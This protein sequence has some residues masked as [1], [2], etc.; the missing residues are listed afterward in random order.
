MTSDALT[1]G[2]LDS[3]QPRFPV[4]LL[5]S[6][7]TVGGAQRTTLALATWL[8]QQGYPVTVA[9]LYDKDNLHA[10]WQADAV[11][12]IINLDSWG[13]KH[14]PLVKSL[15]FVRGISR[16][17]TLLLKQHF[18][19]VLTF[20]HHSDLIGIPLAW[21]AR[22]PVRVANHRG[23]I[24]GFPT[25]LEKVHSRMVNSG[26]ASILVTVTEQAYAQA[27][28]AGVKREHLLVIPNGV[29][30]EL[31][32]QLEA[33]RTQTRSA[34]GIA[35]DETLVL[36]VGRLAPEKGQRYLVEAIPEV[37]K[38]AP[39]TLFAFAGDG[40]QHSALLRAAAETGVDGSI[41]FLGVRSDI[42]DLL[43][44]CDLFVLPSLT[45]GMPNA[46][47]EA[48]AAGLPVVA[49]RAG[50]VETLIHQGETGLL[51][52]TA[53]SHALAEAI[54]TLLN[55]QALRLHVRTAA[56]ALMETSY[57]RSLMCQRFESM[58]QRLYARK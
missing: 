22:V 43:T 14:N 11:F 30:I 53:D 42:P 12:P 39:R 18:G 34:L 15:R 45:E 3:T 46:L 2:V 36:S 9:F 25:W 52:P 10:Q 8:Q 47:M 32:K 56:R 33:K 20:T 24:F 35:S 1:P 4:L 17:L 37:L 29:D 6:Q 58:L 31:F 5:G 26:M 57:S 7:M 16:L 41:R 13:G 38:Q 55:D 19:A 27:V 48:M 21:L 40:P 23:R 49:T 54:L 51:V 28:E 50:G 44:A